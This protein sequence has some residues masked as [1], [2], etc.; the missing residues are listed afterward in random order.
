[1][2]ER[3]HR[4]LEQRVEQ[5]EGPACHRGRVEELAAAVHAAPPLALAELAPLVTRAAEAGD[6]AA[7]AIVTEAASRLTRTAAHVHQPG[8]P[9]VLAGG[10]LTGSEPVRRS[11]TKLLAGETVTTARDTAGAAAWLAARD[12]L[13]ES[14]ARALHTAFTAS[15]CP[16]R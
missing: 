5:E 4:R 6:P 2:L 10:V 1:M 8:L 9:I 13:P 15:P 3:D 11:V 12:L 14:E 7:E 16:V